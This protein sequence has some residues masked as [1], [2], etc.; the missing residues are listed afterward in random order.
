[1]TLA[2]DL[3]KAEIDRLIAAGK[4]RQAMTALK[5][6]WRN[7]MRPAAA[8]YVL[9]RFEQLK[10]DVPL[11][12][13]RLAILRS[14]TVE[15]VTLL[16]QAS[17][18]V[19]G[20]ELALHVGGFNAYMQEMLDPESSLYR[21][22][23]DVTILAVQSRDIAPDLFTGFSALTKEQVTSAI[24][25]VSSDIRNCIETCRS[26]SN[27]HLVVHTL[28]A[29]FRPNDGIMDWQ[30]RDGQTAAFLEI[31]ERLADLPAQYP[32]VYLLDYDGLISETGRLRWHNEQNWA[33]SRLP[34][35]AEALPRL[36]A[37]WL[38]FLHPLTGRTC[39]ALAV[40]L[41]NTMW[42]GIVGEDGINGIRLDAEPPGLAF[43]N[44]QRAI[45]DLYHRGI[46][47]AI[48]SKNNP[49]DAMEVL[50]K[51]PAMLLRPEHFAAMRINWNDKAQS[52]REIAAELNI[53]IDAVAFLDDNPAEREWVRDQEPDVT[54]I[55]LPEDPADY[56]RALRETAVFER[57]TVSAED[58]ERTRYYS[59][60]KQRE[61]S[62]H[63]YTSL[64]DFYRSLSTTVEIAP[65]TDATIARIAQLAQK[66]NQFNMTTKRYSQQE[67]AALAA[68]PNCS[69]YS[70]AVRDR[71]G[72]NGITGV[73]IVRESGSVHEIDTFLLSCRVIGRTVE[74]AILAYLAQKARQAGATTLVGEFFPTKKNAPARDVYR[75]HGF[76]CVRETEAGS[77]W[78]L[79][80]ADTQLQTPPWLDVKIVEEVHS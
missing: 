59:E 60:Q 3:H 34:L 65:A 52:L 10:N 75:A 16:L 41:D 51:H 28:E 17:A 20:I 15:P 49:A 68:N 8:S 73:V 30:R 77:R 80:L 40:D 14:F 9:H 4:P 50:E 31:N 71:F 48:C 58:R 36:A 29:P 32:G 11:R 47:L 62:K 23:P 12:G 43:L 66:T 19:E 5:Q 37:E 13:C 2:P 26:R 42:G 70:V 78:E 55:D 64:E 79:A 18:A 69:V 35:S 7:N 6:F 46:L 61:S 53:G 33:T 74:T 24:A 56:A 22:A 67:I 63:D 54:V 72:D 39:K 27:C 21:F 45:L 76:R 57:L 1:M 25:R 38:R 44:L